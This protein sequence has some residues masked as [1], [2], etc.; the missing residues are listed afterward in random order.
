MKTDMNNIAVIFPGQGSQKVGMGQALAVAYPAAREIFE[1]A[2]DLLG[3]S[4]SSLMWQGP[5]EQL[6]ETINTQPALYVHSMAALKVL[7]QLYPEFEPA[8][9]AGHSLGELTAVAAAGGMSFE[10]GLKLVRRRGELMTHAGEVSPGG[11]AAVL[12]LDIPA[13][14]ALCQQSSTADEFVQVA[15]DNCPGQVVVSGHSAAVGRLV[16]QASAA[17]AKMAKPLAVSIAAHS[18]LMRIVQDDFSQAVTAAVQIMPQVTVIG[19]VSAR[20]LTSLEGIRDDIRDQLTS[21]VRWTE[22]VQYLVEQG[23]THFVEVG[24]G[25]VLT[26]LIKRIDRS[27]TRLKFGEPDDMAAFEQALV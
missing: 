18:E 8:Y 17:G 3:F 25:E 9:M 27:V 6:T 11:M 14:D 4:L 7:Q 13:V 21:R 23:V 16:E 15:N 19:N 12:G 1:Q 5:E 26:G 22:S 10:E 24:S 20:P 2:D